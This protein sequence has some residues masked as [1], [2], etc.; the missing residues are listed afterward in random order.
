MSP[1]LWVYY[2]LFALSIVAANIAIAV[3][4]VAVIGWLIVPWGTFFAGATLV[5]RDAVHWHGGVIPAVSAIATGALLSF[6]FATPGLALASGLAFLIAEG[7]DLFVYTRLAIRSLP[8]AVLWSGVAGA[9][10]DTAVF[11]PLSGLP[12]TPGLVAGQILTKVLLSAGAAVL[13]ARLRRVRTTQPHGLESI[14]RHG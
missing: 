3:F 13:I 12:V 2:H 11:L 14:R 8:A 4:G 9:V 5:L 10:I 7:A 6:G 1:R